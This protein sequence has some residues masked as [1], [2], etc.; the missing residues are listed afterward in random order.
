MIYDNTGRLSI[1]IA[2]ESGLQGTEFGDWYS[3]IN[4]NK[5]IKFYYSEMFIYHSMLPWA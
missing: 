2:T 1:D 4:I 5:M 3:E